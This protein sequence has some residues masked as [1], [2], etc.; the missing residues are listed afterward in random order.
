MIYKRRK[1]IDRQWVTL[2]GVYASLDDLEQE[3]R[4][5]ERLLRTPREKRK[6]GVFS[7]KSFDWGE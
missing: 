6:H 4:F 7:V 5:E 2:D 1:A 3:R